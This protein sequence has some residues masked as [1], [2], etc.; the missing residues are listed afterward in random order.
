M[1]WLD[2]EQRQPG[3]AEL[4]RKRVERLHVDGMAEGM[5]RYDRGDAPAGATVDERFAAPL[6]DVAQIITE[7]PGVDAERRV[8]AVDE[9]RDGAAIADGVRG[10]NEGERWRQH[11]IAGGDA[12]QQQRHVQRRG[13]VDHRHRMLRP[14]DVGDGTFEAGDEGT[15]RRNV[16]AVEALLEVLGL[17]TYEHGH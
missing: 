15:N 6:A 12:H 14:G 3:L 1:R 11:F 13:A 7:R 5:H 4:A 2:M 9:V 8:L 10:G 17:T 16:A